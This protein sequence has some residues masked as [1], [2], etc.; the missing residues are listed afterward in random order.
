MSL[1][2]TS[3]IALIMGCTFFSDAK[4]DNKKAFIK[5][6]ENDAATLNKNMD[7]CKTQRSD[8]DAI[9]CIV[10]AV[11][12]FANGSVECNKKYPK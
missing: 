11:E 1:I 9:K 10:S 4:A 2:K 6:M 8:D 7:D 5:C 12:K 3:A